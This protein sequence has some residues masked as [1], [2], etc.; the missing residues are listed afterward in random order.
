MLV[1]FGRRGHPH[2]TLHPPPPPP[3]RK[4]KQTKTT[5]Q[6]KI[7]TH[8]VHVGTAVYAWRTCLFTETHSLTRSDDIV[9][10]HRVEHYTVRYPQNINKQTKEHLITKINEWRLSKRTSFRCYHLVSCGKPS[11]Q[12]QATL[13]RGN[14]ISQR[15]LRR[16]P[17]PQ[18]NNPRTFLS[19]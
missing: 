15:S 18:E 7:G 3:Q 12:T 2:S 5:K 16:D 6:N 8:C 17:K 14:R 1:L 10:R 11:L 19:S 13:K 4:H 9:G